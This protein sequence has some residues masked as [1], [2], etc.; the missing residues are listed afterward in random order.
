MNSLQVIWTL[1]AVSFALYFLLSLMCKKLN[2]HNL[3]QSLIMV[4]GLRLLNVKH[5]I[6]IVLFGIL[7]YVLIPELH[8]LIVFVEIP[9]LIL[10]IFIL[11]TMFLSAYVSKLAVH[12]HKVQHLPGSHYSF[13]DLWLYVVIRFVFLFSYEFFFRGVLLFKFLEFTTLFEAILYSTIL[14]VLIHIFDSR[15]EILGAIPF[16][17][18]LCLVAYFTKSIWYPF[19]IHLALSA[20]Y[21]ISIFYYQTLKK[22]KL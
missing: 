7:F 9:R 2:V 3:E 19:L 21:E 18:V 8:Y 11:F 6:G 15:K 20:V 14:Y 10:L 5:L 16:G 17:I 12:R 1:I 22:S 13:S 4:N